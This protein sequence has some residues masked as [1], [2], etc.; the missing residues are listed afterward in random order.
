MLNGFFLIRRKNNVFRA[1]DRKSE[2]GTLN[3][4][5]LPVNKLIISI[6]SNFL[7]NINS[8]EQLL[9]KIQR[10]E[11]K[12]ELGFDAHFHRMPLLLLSFS[13]FLRFY[14]SARLHCLFF[15][16]KVFKKIFQYCEILFEDPILCSNR[17]CSNFLSDCLF[18]TICSGVNLSLENFVMSLLG[19]VYLR[20]V[21][22]I[23]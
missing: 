22:I 7:E 15:H 19:R 12:C 23:L 17:F 6:W 20:R 14:S 21:K 16:E 18:I 2:R 4:S 1:S 3:Y 11:R 8:I 9:S 5:K 10:V 13:I